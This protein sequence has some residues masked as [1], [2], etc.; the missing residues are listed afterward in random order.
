MAATQRAGIK[1]VTEPQNISQIYNFFYNKN[2][3]I[4]LSMTL[5]SVGLNLFWS[6]WI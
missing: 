6:L 3:F 2:L 5:I 4:Y 1:N